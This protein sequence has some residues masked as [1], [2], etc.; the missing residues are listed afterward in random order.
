MMLLL[1]MY[2]TDEFT[3]TTKARDS[4]LQ[5]SIYQCIIQLGKAIWSKII[6]ITIMIALSF[7]STFLCHFEGI[8]T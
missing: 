7:V 4:T 1:I 2:T 5:P 8:Q 6:I 3:S